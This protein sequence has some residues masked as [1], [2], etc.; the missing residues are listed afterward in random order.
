MCRSITCHLRPLFW[1][2]TCFVRQFYE[3]Y[4]LCNSLD[5]M[6]ILPLLCKVVCLLPQFSVGKT[7]DLTKQVLLYLYCCKNYIF[8]PQ[9]LVLQFCTIFHQ[10][11]NSPKRVDLFLTYIVRA[12]IDYKNLRKIYAFVAV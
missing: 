6:F 3:V 4:I 5:L 10:C 9:T 12:Q 11:L 7:R 2:T 1:T 8:C